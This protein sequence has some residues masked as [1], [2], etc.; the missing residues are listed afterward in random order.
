MTFHITSSRGGPHEPLQ[1]LAL[2]CAQHK[3]MRVSFLTV[4][5]R[6]LK[7]HESRNRRYLYFTDMAVIILLVAL[8]V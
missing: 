5:G 8:V 2:R 4:T 6:Y 1:V 7:D 3:A